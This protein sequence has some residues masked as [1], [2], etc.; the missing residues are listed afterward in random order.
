M[1]PSDC[2]F[3]IYYKPQK[4]MAK[5]RQS[6][7]DYQRRTRENHLDGDREVQSRARASWSRN[8]SRCV[9]TKC[10]KAFVPTLQSK[11]SETT[12]RVLERLGFGSKRS[13]ANKFPARA[14][15]KAKWNTKPPAARP[16]SRSRVKRDVLAKYNLHAGDVNQTIADC[17]GR[18][19][20][21]HDGR[22][23]PAL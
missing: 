3:Y 18:T 10:L 6:A 21:R 5:G 1:P 22:R 14:K 12:R 4:R 2:D 16:C 11:F 9:S 20:R 17:A 7:D 15:A 13:V 19:D 23:Q 8:R